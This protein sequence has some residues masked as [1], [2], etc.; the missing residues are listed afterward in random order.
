MVIEVAA[1]QRSGSKEA[2]YIL[3]AGRALTPTG[4]HGWQVAAI[5]D[6]PDEV[7]AAVRAEIER[8]ADVIKL[9]PTGGSWEREPTAS[10]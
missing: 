3:A 6:G 5:A 2:P 4:G 1:A 7:R 10:T 8:G 9:I